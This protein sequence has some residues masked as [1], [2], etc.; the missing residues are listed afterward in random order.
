MHQQ[1]LNVALFTILKLAV[2]DS[3]AIKELQ[4]KIGVEVVGQRI[5]PTVAV[6]SYCKPNQVQANQQ[7]RRFNIP[8]SLNNSFII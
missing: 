1:A 6:T 3:L 7:Q 2:E 5:R 4:G 8:I